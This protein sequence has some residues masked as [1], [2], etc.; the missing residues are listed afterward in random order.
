MEELGC[1]E[2]TG[3]VWE[4]L[5]WSPKSTQHLLPKDCAYTLVVYSIH[6]GFPVIAKHTKYKIHVHL[7]IYDHQPRIIKNLIAV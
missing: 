4:V 2:G 5:G 7:K 3:C 6:I 1:V